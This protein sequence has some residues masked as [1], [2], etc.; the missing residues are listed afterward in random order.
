MAAFLVIA[1]R[2]A[3]LSLDFAQPWVWGLPS[4]VPCYG[5]STGS[6]IPAVFGPGGEPVS[7]FLG[8]L[9][10][11]LAL[12]WW[13]EHALS[14]LMARLGRRTLCGALSRW[15]SLSCCGWAP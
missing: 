10:L 7:Q 6:S 9:P 11:L 3:P 12:L 4:S 2:G 13:S 8:A 5:V 1:T 14:H 15:V